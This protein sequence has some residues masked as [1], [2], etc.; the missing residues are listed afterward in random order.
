MEIEHTSSD[1]G[2]GGI[3]SATKQLI[4]TYPNGVISC[5]FIGHMKRSLGDAKTLREGPCQC[6]PRC[7]INRVRCRSETVRS[8]RVGRRM[9]KVSEI[10]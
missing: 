7:V 5:V 4:K 2:L 3:M 6:V 8:G 9:F 1:N 10:S